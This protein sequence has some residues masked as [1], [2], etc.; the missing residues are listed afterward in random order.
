MPDTKYICLDGLYVKQDKPLLEINNRSFLYGDGLFETIHA[1]G[2]EPQFLE[3]H[4]ERLINSMHLLRMEIPSF[5]TSEYFKDHIKGVLT[6]NKQF[7]G[8]RVRITIFRKSGGLYTPET[9]HVS[10]AIDSSLLNSDVYALNPTGLIVD[11]FPDIL[12]PFNTLSMLKTTSSLLFVMA[13]LYRIENKLDDC[14]I[15]N[16]NERICE[17]ISSN[18]FIVKGNKFYTPSLKEGCLPG[19][20]R[21]IM[22]NIIRQN[23]YQLNNDCSLTVKDMLL[24]DE[25]FL[26]NAISGI[27]WVMGFR[28][29]RYYNKTSKILINLLNKT[30]FE[31]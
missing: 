21:D 16:E 12:K 27:K 15:L 7:K 4:L 6:R 13:G 30:A 20:M 14:L 24:A 31:S 28:Q 1:N 9:N 26:T 11:T 23:G 3:K 5:F 10:Y 2:T 17:S 8:A 29:K 19:I 22:C 25:V 18:I